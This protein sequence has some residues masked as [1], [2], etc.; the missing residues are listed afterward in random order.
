[1]VNRISLLF[2][3]VLATSLITADAPRAMAQG[4]APDTA[5]STFYVY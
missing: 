5:E 3:L 4:S 1:M 2:F